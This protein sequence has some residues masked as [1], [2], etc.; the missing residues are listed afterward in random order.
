MRLHEHGDHVI[1]GEGV[2]LV[3]LLASVLVLLLVLGLEFLGAA[4]IVARKP[5]DIRVEIAHVAEQI[6]RRLLIH[7][8]EL[9]GFL[10]LGEFEDCDDGHVVEV[11]DAVDLDPL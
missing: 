10:V 9:L 6:T 4:A 8:G 5:S 2:L 3:P 1:L 11:E 7:L